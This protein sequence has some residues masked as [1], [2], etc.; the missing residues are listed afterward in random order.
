MAKR[1]EITGK[2]C[3]RIPGPARGRQDFIAF[4]RPRFGPKPGSEMSCVNSRVSERRM[5]HAP[6]FRSVM[7]CKLVR[8]GIIHSAFYP[9]NC[10][11]TAYVLLVPF[12]LAPKLASSLQ[13]VQKGKKLKQLFTWR[14]LKP[15]SISNT[16]NSQFAFVYVKPFLSALF[17]C[18]A[19]SAPLFAISRM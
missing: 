7:A 5:K 2:A 13:V 14:V 10:Q 15:L 11:K 18:I 6:A 16:L 12:Q 8:T 19:L 4:G 17:S 9:Y 1:R 3:S